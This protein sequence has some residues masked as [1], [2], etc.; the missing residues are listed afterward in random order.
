M[1]NATELLWDHSACRQFWSKKIESG[2]NFS[3]K[4]TAMEV[5]KNVKETVKEIEEKGFSSSDTGKAYREW[6]LT[7]LDI[8]KKA[9]GKFTN[10]ISCFIKFGR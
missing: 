4:E 1:L 10:I 5:E 6:I 7:V 2:C 3:S 8:L 9:S